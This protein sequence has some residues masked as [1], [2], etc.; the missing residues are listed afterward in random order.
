MPNRKGIILAG[1]WG[2]RLYPTTQACNK[3]LFPVYDKPMIYYPLSTLM[4]AGIVEILLIVSSFSLESYTRLLGDGNQWGIHLS[5]AV[6]PQPKGIAQ[7]FIIAEKF[8]HHHS[9]CLILGDNIL[10]GDALPQFLT[11]ESEKQG[12][13]TVFAYPVNNPSEYGV[14]HFDQHYRILGIEE[15]PTIP[16]SHYAV[17]GLYFYDDQVVDFAKSLRPSPRG[18]LE[19]TDLN[20]QYLLRNQLH[21]H[22][23][24]RGTAWLDAGTPRSLLE[25]SH[26]IATLEERQGLKI[27]APEEIAWRKNYINDDQLFEL[28]SKMGTCH[29]A[30]YLRSLLGTENC[31]VKQIRIA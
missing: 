26:F 11:S 24:S 23:L 19:I 13:A 10:V 28:A 4:M 25:A 20:R 7:A 14:I 15:K 9:V 21:A 30:H 18:E 8:I 3:H 22:I 1:G 12:G 16:K 17:I 6:Q 5:Y 31:R 27:C 29:Y 2:T